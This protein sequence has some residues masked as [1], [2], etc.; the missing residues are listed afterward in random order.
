L[1][2]TWGDTCTLSFALATLIT[3]CVA[4]NVQAQSFEDV[5][6]VTG[7][8]LPTA[9]GAMA[10]D[11][12][13]I[14]RSEIEAR[15][16]SSVVELLRSMPGVAIVQ[17]GGRGSAAS[18]FTRGAKPN[19]TVV[20]IDGVKVNDETN[21]RGGSF[22]FSTLGL[23][24]IERIEIIRG[25]ESAVYGAPAAGGV[26]NIITRR[27]S[28]QSSVGLDLSGGQFG[29]WR[30]GAD[31]SGAVIGVPVSLS[32]SHTDN[33][34]PALGSGYR[35]TLLGGSVGGQF[36]QDLSFEV[37]GRYGMDHA[38]SFPD[39]S[40]GPLLAAIRDVDRR[41]IGEAMFGAR[42]ENQL[43]RHWSQVLQ[44]GL[45]NRTSQ[46]TSPGVAPSHQ[47]P[48]GIPSSFDDIHYRRQEVNWTQIL[49]LGH[50]LRTALGIDWQKEEGVDGGHLKFGQVLA[51]TSYALNREIR[52]AYA[53]ARW[54]VR[55]HW[56]LSV[57]GRNDWPS[58]ATSR[59]SPQ[60]GVVYS[61]VP[62]DT[63]LRFSW[64]E[65][66]KFPSFYALGN[67]IVGD[68]NLKPETSRS[69]EA[70]VVQQFRSIPIEMR[71]QAFKTTYG[72]LI[73]FNPGPT[74]K[75]VNVSEVE[76]HGGEASLSLAI[77]ASL[78]I[79]TYVS[80]TITRKVT[81]A[82]L[83]DVPRWLAGGNAL[84]R[85]TPATEVNLRLFHVSSYIDNA[86]PTGDVRLPGYQRCD[87]SVTRGI[88]Q[89]KVFLAI[90]NLFNRRYE[91]AVGFPSPGL[92]A[93][94]GFKWSL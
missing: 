6:I 35:G 30:G 94:V 19:F 39:A 8:R 51:P 46:E 26:I 4:Q 74:P 5:I 12:T 63:K 93:R 45:Y 47:D 85:L 10:N 58:G 62:W 78:L 65:G 42:L 87:L 88:H 71:L 81:G 24:L 9:L 37:T 32:V 31:A 11:V 22:D 90:E 54:Q 15:N 27:G 13:V 76:A 52:S 48:F 84:W 68:P 23:D 67:P 82:S 21:T 44:Y 25:P 92:F 16:P 66:F 7:T 43:S 91:E 20:M 79:E 34:S 56:E 41:D 29:Y 77:G 1:V 64:G 17:A 60:I 75:L 49:A 70:G 33:G 28:E 61:I 38:E 40:G 80:D 69:I 50:G 3:S 86:V 36:S 73:D 59:I 14:T 53:E 18:A 72:N 2:S 83:R 55:K 89:A 57:A